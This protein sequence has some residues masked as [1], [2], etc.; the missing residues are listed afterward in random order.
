MDSFWATFTKQKV[1]WSPL[2]LKSRLEQSLLG[3]KMPEKIEKKLCP[4]LS[5]SEVRFGHSSEWTVF[6]PL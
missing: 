4:T 2:K 5:E 6:W 1:S 3:P